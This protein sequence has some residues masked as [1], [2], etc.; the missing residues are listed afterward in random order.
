VKVTNV[1]VEFPNEGGLILTISGQKPQDFVVQ[2]ARLFFE[3]DEFWRTLS[4][5]VNNKVLSIFK[6]SMYPLVLCPVFMDN[7][8]IRKNTTH[9][10][11]KIKIPSQLSFL[12]RHFT[13]SKETIV[14]YRNVP[15]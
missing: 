11:L 3:G 9:V 1:H 8:E 7:T 12:G 5:F 4:S 14:R 2:Q 6:F 15:F 10:S 13:I